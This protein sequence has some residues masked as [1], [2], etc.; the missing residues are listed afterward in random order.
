[1]L[2]H[3]CKNDIFQTKTGEI[4]RT[5]DVN[6]HVNFWGSNEYPKSMFIAEIRKIIQTPYHLSLFKVVGFTKVLISWTCWS[7]IYIYNYIVG[8]VSSVL[9][10]FKFS[11]NIYKSLFYLTISSVAKLF[12]N[13]S[14]TFWI[15]QY[16]VGLRT[17]L[18]QPEFHG[19]LV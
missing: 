4:F 16:Y 3:G 13:T 2:Y 15:T 6:I 19:G 9:S 14:L 10:I 18:R 17:F 12:S 11:E 5:S 7:N 8:L 1:M